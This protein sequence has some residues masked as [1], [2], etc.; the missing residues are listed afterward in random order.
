[1]AYVDCVILTNIYF[2]HKINIRVEI[3]IGRGIGRQLS[4]IVNLIFICFGF[5]VQLWSVSP[6]HEFSRSTCMAW[7][8][9]GKLLAVGY[10]SGHVAILDVE[11]NE[12]LLIHEVKEVFEIPIKLIYLKIILF[13]DHRIGYLHFLDIVF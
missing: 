2:E 10:S 6:P 1:M 11:S 12:P 8:P 13:V 4:L 9:D 7:R 3:F 5:Y